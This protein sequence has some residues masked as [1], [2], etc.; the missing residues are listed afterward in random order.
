MIKDVIITIKGV[1]GLDGNTDTIEFVT[2]GR[3]GISEGKYF[4]SYDEGGLIEGG[5]NIKTKLF[6]NGP[7]SVVL[8][9]KGD[10][11]SRMEI[12][13]G[14]RKTCFYNTPVGDITI[15]IY[16]EIVNIDLKENGGVIELAYN[17]DSELKLISQNKVKITVKE[18]K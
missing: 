9:R 14:Q 8:N 18:V 3:F 12:C 2:E 11:T 1:Q 10:I 17:I 4:L 6:I 15:G 5:G 13:S 7:Q 16:G